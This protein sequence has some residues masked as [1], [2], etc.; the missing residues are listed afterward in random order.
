[1]GSIVEDDST[2]LLEFVVVSL[3]QFA[4]TPEDGADPLLGDR[5]QILIPANGDVMVYGDGGA[6]KTTLCLDLACHLAGGNSWLGIDVAAPLTVL[7]VENEGPTALFRGKAKRKLKGW[8]GSAPRRPHQRA[9][10]AVGEVH[11]R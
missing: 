2:P 9:G 1:M 6:G 7:L 10:G 8:T 3:S 4:A 11:V 5:D